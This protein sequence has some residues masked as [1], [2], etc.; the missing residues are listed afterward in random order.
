MFVDGVDVRQLPLDRLRRAIGFVQQEPFLF[1][2]TI[3]DNVAF[4]LDALDGGEACVTYCTV[5]ARRFDGFK[6]GGYGSYRGYSTA[7]CQA[8][9]RDL[10]ARTSGG[11]SRDFARA[12][13]L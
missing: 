11:R 6:G 7:A 9:R 8:E 3:G 12:F 13:M 5:P 10:C 1:S 4:G 2:D